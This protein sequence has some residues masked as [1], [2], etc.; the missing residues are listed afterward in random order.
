MHPQVRL[1]MVIDPERKGAKAT[2]DDIVENEGYRALWKGYST[3]L[4]GNVAAGLVAVM[5]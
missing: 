2:L 1:R 5:L 4:L 3:L